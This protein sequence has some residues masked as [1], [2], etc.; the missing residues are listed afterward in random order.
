MRISN[1]SGFAAN[2]TPTTNRWNF[3]AISSSSNLFKRKRRKK[4]NEFCRLVGMKRKTGLLARTRIEGRMRSRYFREG[5]EKEKT[6]GKPHVNRSVSGSFLL[7]FSFL[8]WTPTWSRLGQQSWCGNR[9]IIWS[10]KNRSI[11]RLL[12]LWWKR[13]WRSW[14]SAQK[15][16][17][18]C[19]YSHPVNNKF[20]YLKEWKRRRA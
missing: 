20:Y 11:L 19:R 17:K 1:S 18:K 12:L 9:F 16:K 6:M 2:K 4:G 15:K 8:T 7:F 3:A 5:E 10:E 13:S 14:N